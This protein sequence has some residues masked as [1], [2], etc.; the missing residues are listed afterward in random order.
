[1]A[2]A[3]ILIVEDEG[4]VA[5]AF[6]RTVTALGHTVVGLAASGQEAI[7]QAAALRPDV[8]LMDIHLRG[9][10]DGIDAAQHIRA[11]APTPVIYVTAYAD[12]PTAARAWQTAPAGYLVKPVGPHALRTAYGQ[13][14]QNC[15]YGSVCGLSCTRSSTCIPAQHR[16]YSR[17][18]WAEEVETERVMDW[19]TLL[20]Y[21][22]GSV[23]QELLLRNE[24]LVTENR[25]LHHQIPSR[26]QLTDGDRKTLAAIGHKL[27]KQALQEVAT[28]VK[29]DTILA[30][31]RKLMAQKFDGS[32]QR[33]SP[34]RPTID[35]ALE[36]LIVRMAQE[37][38]SW[39]Y[40]RI[41]G[42]LANLGYTVSDQTVGNILKRHGIPP[43]P[44]RK[45]TTTWKEFIRTHMDVLVA[46][47]FFT[48][49]VWTL[50][51]LVTYY[52]LSFLY[53]SSRTIHVAGVTPHPDARW[54]RQ[55]ARNVTIAEWGFLSSGQY[56]IHD[57]DGKYCPTFQLILD[58]AGVTRVP[59]PPRSPNLNAYAERWVR[60]V[61]DEALSRMMLFGERS[62]WYTLQQYA[63]H[64]HTER[65]HQGKGNVILM[66]ATR[67]SLRDGPLHCRQRLGGL[68]KY[69][70]R[71]A[72]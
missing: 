9:A 42:A 13:N 62:L 24:Y 53:L 37:N 25:I 44:E 51:G 63:D 48:A 21:I 7:T 4:I 43:A 8:V 19:K 15:L 32:K 45:T 34:G 52:V 64:Y 67:S 18:T 70:H 14:I 54:M 59:L 27:S 20:A 72:A 33:Q 31:H 71:D 17:S 12:E 58:D 68:L 39:G 60:S 40:D 28:I 35:P 66:P 38:R 11:Q 2:A 22:T 23:D 65:P 16:P 49:E 5:L 46:T 56:L 30:W 36:T 1:M 29:P 10:M 3:R 6:R 26:V 47:D 41:V 61:K 57:R 55:I 50:G 69:Y